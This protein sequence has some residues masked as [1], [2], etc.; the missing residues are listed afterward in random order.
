MIM[1]GIYI[2]H[3]KRH[4]IWIDISLFRDRWVRKNPVA[5]A[6][7]DQESF[8]HLPDGRN[9]LTKFLVGSKNNF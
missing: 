3:F 6:I 7:R 9:T 8:I 1:R 2:P 5:H 4:A